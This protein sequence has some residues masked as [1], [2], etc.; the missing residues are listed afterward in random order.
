MRRLF[1]GA[2]LIIFL[3][4]GIGL[5]LFFTAHHPVAKE[6]ETIEEDLLAQEEVETVRN[7]DYYYGET[8]VYTADVVRN[9][10]SEEWFFVQ[11]DSV[12][13]KIK[14]EN[15]LSRADAESMVLDRFDLDNVRSMK[16]GFEDGQ[17][18]YEA[19]FEMN[20]I[21]YF[22]YMS[23]EDGEFIKRYSVQKS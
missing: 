7:V 3:L 12:V 1:L 18:L 11:D 9:N 21:L 4:L 10:G 5:I 14:K 20:N 23:L 13:K 2:G 19:T 22:Y 6:V 15:G 8:A 17:A 16:P